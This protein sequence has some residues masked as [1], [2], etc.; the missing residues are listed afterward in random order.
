MHPFLKTF[1]KGVDLVTE[2]DEIKDIEKACMLLHYLATETEEV[3]DVELTLEKIIL[4]IPLETI[5]DYQIPLTANDKALCDE[6]LQAV[7]TH[8]V[9]LKKSTINTLRDMF[10]KRDG[11][12]R[13]TEDS[14]KLKI[15]HMAQDILLEKIPWN[16]SLFRLKW[17]EKMVHIEW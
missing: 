4:G 15:E 11:H 8:W 17:M 5:I 1:L 2:N 6:L 9:V 14:I 13:I 12:I 16:I 3:T 10:L 7:L